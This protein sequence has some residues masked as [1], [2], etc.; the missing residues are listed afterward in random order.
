MTDYQVRRN[1]NG[2]PWVMPHDAGPLTGEWR[3]NAKKTWWYSSD[4]K[5]YGRASGAGDALDSKEGLVDWAA[6]QA[7]VGLMLNDSARSDVVTLINEYD[8]DPWNLGDDGTAHSGKSRLKE[9]VERARDT[10]GQNTAS[11]AGTEFHKLAELWNQGKPPRVVQDH[12]RPFYDHYREAVQGI[13][14]LGQE[15][16]IINDELARAGSADYLMELPGGLTTPDGVIHDEMVVVGDLKTGKWD[17]KR[18]MKVTCQLA[19]YGTGCRYEQ[20]TNT[21]APLH[22]LINTDWG[23][24]VHFPIALKDARVSFYWVDLNLGL[25]AA[26]LAGQVEATRNW[27]NG[28]SASLKGFS[29]V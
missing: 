7:A 20:E 22:E 1:Y 12:L 14:F 18:P 5:A 17:A 8:A 13:K 2:R 10:A 6:C 28:K 4:A 3:R 21:R 16:L 23:V 29:L 24:M 19:T 15:L 9:A 25:R 26:K 11:S 27:F